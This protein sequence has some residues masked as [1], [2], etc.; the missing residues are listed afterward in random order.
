MPHPWRPPYI[1]LVAQFRATF[2]TDL[3]SAIATAHPQS[4]CFAVSVNDIK[5]GYGYPKAVRFEIGEQGS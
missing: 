4:Q 2:T 1:G 3:L 5:G